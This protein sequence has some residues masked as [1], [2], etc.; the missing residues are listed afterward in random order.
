MNH[1]AIDAKIDRSSLG[2]KSAVIARS[3]VSRVTAAQIVARS[4]QGPTTTKSSKK[5]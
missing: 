3:K 4:Q 2:T 1:E 5:S